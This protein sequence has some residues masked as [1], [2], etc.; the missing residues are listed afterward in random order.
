MAPI[1]AVFGPDAAR[2][3][4]AQQVLALL[5]G[6]SGAVGQGG[7]MVDAVHARMAREILRQAG[8]PA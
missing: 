5:E 1:N 2:V 6:S 8:L 4:W 3:D 7:T